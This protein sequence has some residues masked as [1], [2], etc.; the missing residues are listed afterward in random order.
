MQDR[1]ANPPDDDLFL[2]DFCDMG[3]V[4]T[5]VLPRTRLHEGDAR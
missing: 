3:T 5:V 1:V 4:F 2:P